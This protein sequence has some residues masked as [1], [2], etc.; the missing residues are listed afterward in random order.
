MS[1]DENLVGEERWAK[2]EVLW[3]VLSIAVIFSVNPFILILDVDV[4]VY[5]PVPVTGCLK[6]ILS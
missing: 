2:D 5:H 4:Q 6:T 3:L 1:S